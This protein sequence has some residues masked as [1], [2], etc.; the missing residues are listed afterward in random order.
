MAIQGNRIQAIG[1]WEELKDLVHPHTRLLDAWGKTLLPGFNDTHIHIWKVGNLKTGMLDLRGAGSLEEMLSLISDYHNRHPELEWVTARGFNEASWV[2]GRLPDKDD[3]D[4]VVKDK[5]VFVIRTC[6]HIA[7][8]NSLAMELAGIGPRTTPPEGGLIH[9]NGDGHP[10]G[11]FSETALG[12]IA[13]HIPPNS[14]KTLKEMTLAA[15]E[16]LYRYG[17]TAATDPAV[18]PILLEA[19]AEMAAGGGLGFRLDAIP[20]LLPDGGEQPYPLPALVSG[21]FF[22]IRAVKFFSDGGLSGKT[23]ALKGYYK[24]SREQGILRLEKDQ[25]NRLCRAAMERGLGVA[26]HAIGDAAIEFVIAEYRELERDFPGIRKRIEHLGLPEERQLAD[27]AAN[28]IAASMQTIFLDELGKNFIKYL[29]EGYLARCYPV[30]SVLRQGILLAL[31]SD[32]PVVKNLNPLKGAE[33]AVTRKDAEGNLIAGVEAISMEEALRAYTL[34][35]AR[36]SGTGEFGSL[37]QGK[38]ADFILLNRDPLV[39]PLREFGD[40]RVEQTFVDGQCV[41]KQDAT[42]AGPGG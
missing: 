26:T 3:L 15:R 40:I 28:H 24:D 4:R 11:I 25:Y 10:D 41:W 38:F 37:E 31:S 6:A 39:S 20:M 30:R 23:A 18:D 42:P 27:M 21:D 8:A 13:R 9:T 35:A 1:K 7:I 5:P 22:N 17:I 34:D 14:K 33:A 16:E 19:Y 32:A 2:Q 36:L 29:D 12:L